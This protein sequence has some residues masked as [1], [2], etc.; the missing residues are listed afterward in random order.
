[1]ARYATSEKQYQCQ[2]C[3]VYLVFSDLRRYATSIIC[4]NCK[5]SIGSFSVQVAPDVFTAAFIGQGPDGLP[6]RINWSKEQIESIYTY[7]DILE[8]LNE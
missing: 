4:P 3:D 6:E 7:D 2:W 1:M 5:G 8:L